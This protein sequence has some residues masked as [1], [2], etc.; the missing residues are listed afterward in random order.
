YV[1]TKPSWIHVGI[2]RAS[3]NK[4]VRFVV[5]RSTTN[6]Q[7]LHYTWRGRNDI[8]QIVAPGA[9]NFYVRVT[10]KYGNTSLREFSDLTVL[11][12]VIIVSLTQERLWAYQGHHLVATS[13]VTT[14]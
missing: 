12:K 13:L 3:D 6:N 2:Y 7:L 1:V 5:R 4:R 10:D 8:G 11:N 9:Y 14:G